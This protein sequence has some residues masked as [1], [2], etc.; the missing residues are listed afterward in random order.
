MYFFL[1]F[2]AAKIGINTGKDK[3]EKEKT[4]KNYS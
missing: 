3:T 1:V 2:E 4:G